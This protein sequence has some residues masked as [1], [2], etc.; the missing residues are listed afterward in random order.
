MSSRYA[1][2]SGRQSSSG[3]A[4]QHSGLPSIPGGALSSPKGQLH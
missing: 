1:G 4:G 2:S 3:F